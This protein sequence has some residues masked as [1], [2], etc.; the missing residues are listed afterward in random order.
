[1]DL[2]EPWQADIGK[3]KKIKDGPKFLKHDK[4]EV[5]LVYQV[6]RHHKAVAEAKLRLSQNRWDEGE[7]GEVEAS[8]WK[9]LSTWQGDGTRH[10]G[11]YG[12]MSDSTGA[13]REKSYL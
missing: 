6:G 12:L 10:R 13:A 8:R 3:N 1:M 5:Q 11:M 2:H 9:D 4:A 7:G